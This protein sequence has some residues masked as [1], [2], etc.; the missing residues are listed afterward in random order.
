MINSTP[1]KEVEFEEEDEEKYNGDSKNS[2][3][4]IKFF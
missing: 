3:L 4:K 1:L 2:F